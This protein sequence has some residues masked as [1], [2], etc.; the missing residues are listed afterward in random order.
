MVEVL[1]AIFV[2][3]VGGIFC[4]ALAVAL[5]A[6]G[7]THPPRM[8][9]GKAVYLL[10]RLSPADLGMEFQDVKFHISEVGSSK[11]IV[12]VA[13]WIPCDS[14]AKTVVM[15][16]GFAD[17]KIGAIAWSEPWR[18]LGYN[19]LAVD[20][21]AHGES[22]GKLCTAGQ[23]ESRDILQLLDQLRAQHPDRAQR[24][25][26]FGVSLGAAVAAIVAS[27]REDICAVVLDS[28]FSSYRDAVMTHAGLL[29]QPAKLIAPAALSLV[30]KLTG[31]RF[32]DIAP[33]RIVPRIKCPVL[34]IAGGKDLFFDPA[35]FDPRLV[36]IFPD[37]GHLLAY[38]SAPSEYR[39][40]LKEFLNGI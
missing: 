40:T 21:R 22:D 11:K 2:F 36:K 9:D 1:V 13:W 39:R 15:L 19:I 17:A 31:A 7:L 28:P 16:H 32:D 14:S 8:T 33:R 4:W 10:G 25:V 30:E 34:I 37:A 29:R 23:L 5:F 12:L 24:I 35:A 38:T 18:E 20:L 26:L 3:M 6:H 27:Q